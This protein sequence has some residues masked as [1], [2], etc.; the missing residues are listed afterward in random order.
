MQ[1][2]QLPDPDDRH[3]QD[4][5]QHDQQQSG[6]DGQP[7]IALGASGQQGSTPTTAVGAPRTDATWC[8]GRVGGM[9]SIVGHGGGEC[10]SRGSDRS[11][12]T[13][14][15]F[16]EAASPPLVRDIE[17]VRRC[18]SR[19]GGGAAFS[20]VCGCVLVRCRGRGQ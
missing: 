16:L 2:Q 13:M 12:R 3:A 9:T 7:L 11:N 10:A 19:S 15:I 18:A 20:A 1:P 4:G 6:Q 5:E 14:R 17:N 8:V